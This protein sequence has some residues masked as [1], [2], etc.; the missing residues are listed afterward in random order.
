MYDARMIAQEF[1]AM[2]P[3]HKSQHKN[4]H[5]EIH[6]SDVHDRRTRYKEKIGRE[7]WT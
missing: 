3:T 5:H 6:G 2:I 4:A 7:K 1:P